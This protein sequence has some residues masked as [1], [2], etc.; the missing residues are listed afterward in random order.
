M[1]GEALDRNKTDLTHAATATCAAWLD[2]LGC[3]PVETEVPVGNGWV[4]DL[5][6]FWSPTCTEAKKSRLL[7]SLV[8]TDVVLEDRH[9]FERMYREYGGRFTVV[10]EVK[11]TRADFLHD[12]G[13]KFGLISNKNERASLERPANLCI[14]ACPPGVLRPDERFWDWGMLTLSADCTR[15]VR[16][17]CAWSYKAVTNGQVEDLIAA[18]AIR[19]D[20]QTRYQS[21]RRFLKSHRAREFEQRQRRRK[22]NAKYEMEQSEAAAIEA[23]LA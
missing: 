23:V 11:V 2:S 12:A 7:R 4:A 19:R 21:M 16:S 22:A 17:R 6:S 13:R 9:A 18:V 10:V 15:V 5:A 14:L 20:H 3:K 1:S 8:P